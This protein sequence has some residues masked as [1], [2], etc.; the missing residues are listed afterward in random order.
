MTKAID[1]KKYVTG[2]EMKPAEFQ[3]ERPGTLSEAL[4]LLAGADG[5]EVRALAGGQSLMP[6]MNFRLAA[7]DRLVDLNGIGELA[8]IEET[9]ETVRIGAMTRYSALERSETVRQHL[10]LVASA[11][12]H[13]A[14]PAI[15]NR[16][17]IGG[18]V[19]LADPAAEMPAVL[20]ALDATII[21]VSERGERQV[22]ADDFFLGLY[23]TALEPGEIVRAVSVP[24]AS[25]TARFA[26][27]ELARR[28]G[29]YAMAGVAMAAQGKEPLSGLR[30]AFFGACDRAIR[31]TGAEEALNGHAAG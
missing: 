3:Y 7:P 30:I 12:P 5:G 20:L 4:S 31:A 14:H 10:P 6:M 17:T 1:N 24:K 23:E 21:V 29:D 19:A 16:G 27:R 8:G 13:I 28:H 9:G 2:S 26:F 15:R 25:A 11:L 22:K 18:S